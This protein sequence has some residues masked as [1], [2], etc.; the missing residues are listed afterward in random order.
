[1]SLEGK[2]IRNEAKTST[3]SLSSFGVR[4]FSFY[5]SSHLPDIPFAPSFTAITPAAIGNL[6]WY[7]K[8]ISWYHTVA[9]HLLSLHVTM[10]WLMSQGMEE[11]LSRYWRTALAYQNSTERPSRHYYIS[12][13]FCVYYSRSDPLSATIMT[14][15]I[16]LSIG[17]V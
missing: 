9:E 15:L 13:C 10:F 14:K 11:M 4:H 17:K 8:A 1:M 3:R 5:S 6:V 7:Y 16:L 12:E 2:L